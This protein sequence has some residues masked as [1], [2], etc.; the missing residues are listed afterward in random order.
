[1]EFRTVDARWL[2]AENRDT[3]MT[4]VLD[5]CT[6]G[7]HDFDF[8]FGQWNVF[9]RQ[10]DRRLAGSLTWLEFDATADVRPCLG[11]IGNVDEYRAIFPDGTSLIAMTVRIFDPATRLW[12][13]YWADSRSATL[14]PP[15]KGSFRDGVGEFRGEDLQDGVPVSVIFRW[16][17]ITPTSARWEQAMSADG[18]ATWEWN[19]TM[20]FARVAE[21]AGQ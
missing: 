4:E 16:S 14:F 11:G 15:V 2:Q 6:D 12:S 3:P 1:M 7:R 9:N 8:L 10:L 19:W 5:Q 21:P 13:L 17:E 20:E 18:G